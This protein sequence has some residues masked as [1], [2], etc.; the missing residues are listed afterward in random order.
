MCVRQASDEVA[1]LAIAAT[2]RLLGRSLAKDTYREGK[3]CM[4]SAQIAKEQ[5]LTRVA[6]FSALRPSR[7]AFVDRRMPGHERAIVNVIGCGVTEDAS[8]Q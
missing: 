3:A 7:Q 4:A 6:R 1:I 2:A 8:L 5:M